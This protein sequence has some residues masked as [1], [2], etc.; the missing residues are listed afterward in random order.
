MSKLVPQLVRNFDFELIQPS[1]K[2]DTVNYWFVKPIDFK[3]KVVA[4]KEQ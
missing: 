1:R 3:V 4:R 2:W